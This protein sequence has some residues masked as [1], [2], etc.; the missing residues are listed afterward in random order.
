MQLKFTNPSDLKILFLARKFRNNV[1]VVWCTHGWLLQELPERL[2]ETT[3]RAG[4]MRYLYLR[5]IL[6]QGNSS[7]HPSSLPLT[8]IQSRKTF[9]PHPCDTSFR[10]LSTKSKAQRWTAF[11]LSVSVS[12]S[13]MYLVLYVLVILHN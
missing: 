4:H 9:P 2:L 5:R 11:R 8:A 6:V 1:L 13:L 7:S 3:S 10:F 12:V